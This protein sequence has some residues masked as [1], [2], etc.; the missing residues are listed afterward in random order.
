MLL[1]PLKRSFPSCVIL[2]LSLIFTSDNIF[3]QFPGGPSIPSAPRPSVPR[4]SVPRPSAPRPGSYRPSP[5][6]PSPYGGSRTNRPSTPY[7]SRPSSTPY[8]QNP[9]SN[10]NRT[11]NNSFLPWSQKPS[12]PLSPTRQPLAPSL[13]QRY[14]SART[15]NT[16]VSS[17]Q[18][19]SPRFGRHS[20]GQIHSGINVPQTG[21][22]KQIESQFRQGNFSQGQAILDSQLEHSSS[23]ESTMSAVWALENTASPQEMVNKYRSQALELANKQI[24]ANQVQSPLP[25]IAVA[26]FSLED[27]DPIQF[28]KATNNLIEKYPNSEYGPYFQGIQFL[29]SQDWKAAEVSLNKAH[30]L[31][32][33]DE[34]INH[35]I[36][37]AI[38]NQKWIWTY[39]YII[40]VA[41][42]IWIVLSIFLIF[43]GR[44]LSYQTLRAI[45]INRGDIA[46]IGWTTRTLYRYVINLA[47]LYYFLSL[48][49]LLVLTLALPASLAYALLMLPEIGFVLGAI[50]LVV[51]SGS[52]LTVIAGIR[53][54]FVKWNEDGE[55]RSLTRAESPELWALCDQVAKVV[56]TRSIDQIILTP[57][58]DLGVF[59]RGSLSQ[60]MRDRGERF[61]VVGMGI[62][63]SFQVDAF[64][65]VLA[66]EYGHFLNRD[67][68]GGGLAMQVRIAMEQWV[69]AIIIRGKIRWWD[70]A[71]RF[72]FFY[73][74]LFYKLS[75]G[76]ERLQEILA[77]RIS[78]KAYGAKAFCDGLQQAHAS[79]FHFSQRIDNQI[80]GYLRGEPITK[81]F[82]NQEDA[83]DLELI[84]YREQVLLEI[85]TQPSTNMDTHPAPA[86]RVRLAEQYEAQKGTQ[87]SKEDSR[88]VLD[89]LSNRA[90]LLAEMNGQ[91]YHVL[92]EQAELRAYK[93]EIRLQHI[94]SILK[95]DPYP[96]AYSERAIVYL[97]R[98]RYNE[99]LADI[100]YV[101]KKD[102]KNLNFQLGEA[103]ILSKMRRD[104]EAIDRFEQLIKKDNEML[105]PIN[106]IRMAECF[107]R[108]NNPCKSA[109]A[110]AKAL[111]ISPHSIAAKLGRGEA[112]LAMQQYEAALENFEN[113]TNEFPRCGEAHL[114][115]AKAQEHLGEDFEAAI[116]RIT[117]SRF[118]PKLSL[119]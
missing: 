52:V 28:N 118:V 5:S 69:N 40:L 51:G 80:D 92:G 68:A 71:V 24:N 58:T 15:S 1:R 2:L 25:W 26:K 83:S 9:Q 81:A 61:L 88:L 104:H 39:V 105:N 106:Y 36:K 22:W 100:Q 60:R 30:D 13:R 84:E 76:A 19:D 74:R 64:C 97:N 34:S 48:P 53:A 79:D 54:A 73:G 99:A 85:C 67:T 41:I 86:E 43:I 65:A 110:F 59:E 8:S 49:V 31:G 16:N 46:K 66:H 112:F 4:P 119:T 45:R 96:E 109:E 23:L 47:S 35:L 98:G 102:P 75:F 103:S 72:L 107:L 17:P 44:F 12:T 90:D 117:A 7:S 20:I 6:R 56:G 62:L 14:P 55:M 114:G 37:M 50:V 57:G 101:I 33:S 82:Y 115:I 38:D 29:Q 63:D 116:S 108:V 89:I 77:D 78:V 10:T 70:I 95:E 18:I 94:N 11:R 21:S 91:F 111:D 87:S 27:N 93:Q 3:A 113:I 42:G 32:M